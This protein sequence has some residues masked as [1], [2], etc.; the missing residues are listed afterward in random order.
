MTNTLTIV[1]LIKNNTINPEIAGL[2]WAAVDE[3]ISFLVSAVYRNAGKSTLSKAM[4]SLR[5]DNVSLHYVSDSPEITEKLLGLEK[6]GGYLI[7]DEFNPMD[8]PG[9]LWGEEAKHVFQMARNGYSLQGSIHSENAEQ[10]ITEITQGIGVSDEDASIIQLVLFIEMFGTS[11][12]DA[13]R[14][15]TEIYEVHRV[16]GGKPL[17]H[18]LYKWNKDEDK[19]ESVEESHLF[20]RNKEELRKRGEV[21]GFLANMNKNTEED[22][23]KTI[24]EFNGEQS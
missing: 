7:V 19:F 12:A 24:K 8:I 18:L 11:A 15:V 17:G 21:L 13:V 22:I 16:E 23:K 14:R 20:A 3:K 4:L 1:D 10:A 9:Y 2:L 5:R 6:H